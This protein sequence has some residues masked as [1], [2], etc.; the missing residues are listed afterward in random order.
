[1]IA[2]VLAHSRHGSLIV[3]RMDYNYG[4][5]DEVYGVG[6]QILENGCYD[7][8]EVD[9]IKSLLPL[10]RQ[11]RGN[12][13]VALDCGANIGV[14][15]LEWAE[16]MSGWGQVVAVEAQERI[17]YALAGNIALHNCFNAR[18]IWAAVSDENGFIDIPE[19]NYQVPSSFGSFELKERLGNENIGQSINYDKPTSRVR[20]MTIDSAGF[21]RVD[22]IKMD[23]E[24]MELEALAGAIDTI[25]RDKPVLFIE[26]VK[27]DGKQ[28]AEVIATLGY[29]ML[30]YGMSSLCIHEDDP[31]LSHVKVEKK[32]A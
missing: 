10:L 20:T 18:A 31:I 26:T 1:M 15:A 28:L 13:V 7:P 22:L 11:Y 5:N 6:S 16:M 12:G 25:K 17:Y 3:N 4:F 32:A 27:I 29:R 19:P 14:H 23:I 2:F 9:T 21:T 24:G 8:G 30:P